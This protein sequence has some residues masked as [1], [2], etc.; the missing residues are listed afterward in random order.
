MTFDLQKYIERAAQ[1]APTDAQTPWE[2]TSDAAQVVRTQL[3]ACSGDDWVDVGEGKAHKTATISEHAII[4]GPVFIGS[5]CQIGPGA[6]LRDGVWLEKGVTIG[7]HAE[8]KASFIYAGSRVA[9]LNY[10]GNSFIGEDVNL[11][12]GAVLANHWNERDGEAIFLRTPNGDRLP[13]GVA[14]FGAILGDGVR[15]GAN[16][17]TSPGTVLARKAVVDRLELVR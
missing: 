11:E 16:A 14:K 7:S 6:F 10:V 13:T 2:I 8:I 17:V 5:Y 4:A 1:L 15:V 3:E 12:A 9:H